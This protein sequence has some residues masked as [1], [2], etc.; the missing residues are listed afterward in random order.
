MTGY[1]TTTVAE[2]REKAAPGGRTATQPRNVS[3]REL[4]LARALYR[5]GDH[6]GLGEKILRTY[7][8]D[9]RGHYARHARAVL[10][11]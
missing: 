8:A 7:A 1:A 9:L 5:L 3:L 4:I 11:M 2:A 6:E 10:G